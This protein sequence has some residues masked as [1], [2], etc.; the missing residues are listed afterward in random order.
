MKVK[1]LHVYFGLFVDGDASKR[2]SLFVGGDAN[3]KKE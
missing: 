2:K 1:Y 3:K